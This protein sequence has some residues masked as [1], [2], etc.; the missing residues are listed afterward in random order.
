MKAQQINTESTDRETVAYP[1]RSEQELEEVAEHLEPAE[2]SEAEPV[3][4]LV[5]RIDGEIRDEVGAGNHFTAP[6][7]SLNNPETDTMVTEDGR[8]LQIVGEEFGQVNNTL[9]EY[10]IIGNVQYWAA[11]Q[12]GTFTEENWN[13][14]G[15]H[16][17]GNHEGGIESYILRVDGEFKSPEQASEMIENMNIFQANNLFGDMEVP[18]QVMT[19]ERP[20]EVAKNEETS[21]EEFDEQYEKAVELGLVNR[22]GDITLKGWLSAM[23]LEAG[24]MRSLVN[25]NG[26]VSFS[27][28]NE[29]L[30]PG[31]TGQRTE[32]GSI[33][34]QF[35]TYQ[36]DT[37][38]YR[39]EEEEITSME[40]NAQVTRTDR[41]TEI[42]TE[43][44][45]EQLLFG[46]HS[47]FLSELEQGTSV[48]L[49]RN[50]I[51]HALDLIDSDPFEFENLAG[52]EY[53][54][55]LLRLAVSELE[56]EIENPEIAE[57]DYRVNTVDE[58]REDE[59]KYDTKAERLEETLSG[60]GYSTT[61]ELVEDTGWDE[62]IEWAREKLGEAEAEIEKDDEYLQ[63]G[64]S[65]VVNGEDEEDYWSFQGFREYVQIG[66]EGVVPEIEDGELRGEAKIDIPI[67]HMVISSYQE[68][69]KQKD[70]ELIS[71]RGDLMEKKRDIDGVHRPV[72]TRVEY[73]IES[74]E[75]YS[76]EFQRD[77]DRLREEGLA[78]IEE[79]D[80]KTYISPE[81]GRGNEIQTETTFRYDVD[82]IVPDHIQM[83]AEYNQETEGIEVNEQLERIGRQL[84][85]MNFETD[86]YEDI[87]FE[88]DFR[89]A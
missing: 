4:Q 59:D 45:L 6:I 64:I 32:I 23:D 87:I 65:A 71:Q 35:T 16:I 74:L 86:S 63:G 12:P 47:I 66:W 17:A 55:Q 9:P 60:L 5:D 30:I 68:E 1:E 62:E 15:E 49:N 10:S 76:E 67:S 34:L 21:R 53:G 83:E 3:E 84:D 75:D 37:G 42:E 73:E 7:R 89:P 25:N 44:E 28:L 14:G 11:A 56:A 13:D 78:T 46:E 33:D 29:D 52:T 2:R 41:Y 24:D 8:E 19:Y 57:A 40:A 36:P 39:P 80:G 85:P 58:I 26:T 61:E 50:Q 18:R 48:T 20:E 82:R 27:N 38:G 77:I 31:E 88:T 51:R 43:E 70:A 22:E 54:E 72:G 69:L 79:E 81:S